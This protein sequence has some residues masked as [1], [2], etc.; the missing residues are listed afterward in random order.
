VTAGAAPAGI[1]PAEAASPGRSGPWLREERSDLAVDRLLDAAGR[2]FADLGVEATRMED[3]ARYARCSRGTVYRYFGSG[4]GLRAAYV[5]REARRMAA[6]VARQIDADA[7][8]GPDR[9]LVTGVTASLAAVRADPV[10]RAWFTAEAVGTTNAIAGHSGEVFAMAAA[11]CDRVMDAAA[12]AG[13]LRAGVTRADATEW[14]VRVILSLLT[15]EPPVPRSPEDEAE[16]VRRFVLP[17]VL[18]D[19]EV[20]APHP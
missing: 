18:V 7:G 1:A 2:A 4:E 19:E 16:L 10:L 15:L 20:P 14:I 5:A 6:A 12:A 11:L 8:A 13:R 3:V 17:A 9:V